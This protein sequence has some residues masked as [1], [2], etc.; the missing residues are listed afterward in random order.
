MAPHAGLQSL[1]RQLGGETSPRLGARVGWQHHLMDS[2]T[3]QTDLAPKTWQDTRPITLG[4]PQLVRSIAVASRKK[5][6]A[7]G[8]AQGGS[9]CKGLEGSD[10]AGVAGGKGGQMGTSW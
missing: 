10:L 8:A 2:C 4:R 3:W 1:A 9:A 5:Q 7:G 6:A